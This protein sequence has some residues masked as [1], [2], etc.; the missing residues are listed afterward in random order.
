MVEVMGYHCYGRSSR[1]VH[2]LL[3]LCL[4]AVLVCPLAHPLLFCKMLQIE[5]YITR[6]PGKFSA[7]KPLPPSRLMLFSF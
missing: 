3:T 5:I 2:V 7:V 6:N 1:V 4:I